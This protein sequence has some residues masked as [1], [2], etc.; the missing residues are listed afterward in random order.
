MVGIEGAVVDRADKLRQ[1]YGEMGSC[2]NPPRT[3]HAIINIS[4]PLSPPNGG[5]AP[6]KIVDSMGTAPS[7]QGERCSHEEITVFVR[8]L[9]SIVWIVMAGAAAGRLIL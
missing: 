5:G 7:A 2:M 3:T 8:P 9:G 1:R 4:T 6:P